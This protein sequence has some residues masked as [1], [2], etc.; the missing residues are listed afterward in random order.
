MKQYIGDNLF[1]VIVCGWSNLTTAEAQH[2]A[3]EAVDKMA[4]A[5]TIPATNGTELT[6]HAWSNHGAMDMRTTAANL[7]QGYIQ[8]QYSLQGYRSTFWS[9]AAFSSQLSTFLWAYNLEYLVPKVVDSM[10]RP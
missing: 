8:E 7:K 3:S 5:G 6:V 10:G 2:L 1:Q 9:G 4:T